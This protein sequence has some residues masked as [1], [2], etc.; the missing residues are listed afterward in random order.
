MGMIDCEETL[1]INKREA[2]EAINQSASLAFWIL[3]SY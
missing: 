3:K 1:T 2:K